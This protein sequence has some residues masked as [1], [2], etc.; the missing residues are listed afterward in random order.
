[1]NYYC[2]IAGLQEPQLDN[3]K[4]APTMADLTLQLTALLSKSDLSLLNILRRQY[5]NQNLLTLQNNKDAEISPLGVLTHQDWMEI[6]E[7]IA[8]SDSLNPPRDRRLLPYVLK[9][10]TATSQP[11]SNNNTT[12]KTDLLASLYYEYGL[13][14]PNE[15]IRAWFEYNL[16]VGNILTALTC[17][18][19]NWDIRTAIVGD[20]LIANTIRNSTSVRD[21]NL[22]TEIDYFDQIAAISE[23]PDLLD[24]ERRIDL[25]K[26]QW[27]ERHTTFH[28][29]S[30]EK[31][32]AHYLR[33]QIIH[34]WDNLSVEQGTAIFRQM[35]NDL[36]KDVKF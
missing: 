13:K 15:F 28:Y 18:K 8:E 27:L 22:K 14:S 9:Y 2:Y 4:S 29:F 33:C 11:D 6:F 3:T 10:I 5:D 12:F 36:K 17:R 24:R 26:W 21:F 25:L 30:I 34:R 20:N 23:I 19:H 31:I 1:M 16:N 7:K 35:I 32:L